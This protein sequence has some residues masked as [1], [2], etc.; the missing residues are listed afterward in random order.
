MTENR[1]KVRE[2]LAD[3]TR[4][5]VCIAFS[6]GVD[7]SLLL[8]L[9]LAEAKRHDTTVYA[10]TFDTQLHP[11]CD[12]QIARAVAGEMGARHQVIEVDELANPAIL[13]NPV[14]RCY[15]CKKELFARLLEFADS[16]NIRTVLEGTNRDDDFQ[17]RP[18]IRAVE[19]LGVLSPLRVC[20]LSKREIRTWAKELG[21]AVA[22]RPSTPCMATRLPYGTV[23]TAEILKRI[24]SGEEFLKTFGFQN[25][26][27]RVHGDIARVELDR[28]AFIEAVDRSEEILTELKKLGFT[29]VTLD[30]EGFRS[31]SMDKNRNSSDGASSCPPSEL[32]RKKL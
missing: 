7:S 8:K 5:D 21:I 3:I 24:E 13:K 6:G 19:E 32:L 20:G 23:I 11:S 30:L 10:V 2:L 25:V 4:K 27:L 12:I 15:L 1:K 22:D 31:G 14:D 18:G 28:G 26:R 16:K 9:A 17:Y 29:Y